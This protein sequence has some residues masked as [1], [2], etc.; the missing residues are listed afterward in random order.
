VVGES[1]VA[2]KANALIAA[3]SAPFTVGDHLHYI[4]ASVGMALFPDDAE[5][6]ETLLRHADASMQ[7]AKLSGRGSSRR[8]SRQWRE[9]MEKDALLEIRLHSALEA[10]EFFLVYQPQVS[11][12]SRK[13]VGFEALIRWR[14]ADGS[15]ISPGQFIPLAERSGLIAEIDRYVVSQGARQIAEWN[16]A[17]LKCVPVSFNLSAGQFRKPGVEKQ[18]VSLLRGRGVDPRNAVFEITE[19][20]AMADLSQTIHILEAWRALGIGVGIDD[21][22]TGFSSLNYLRQFPASSLKIDQSF[23]RGL[24]EFPADR[25]LVESILDMGKKLGLEIVAEG[26]EKPSQYEFLL[27]R[28]CDVIQGYL[29]SKPISA[30]AAMAL[31]ERPDEP[32]AMLA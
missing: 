9:S 4:G 23:V 2:E 19:T 14:Q 7:Q 6:A 28:G 5:D 24:D 31:L 15:L 8:V 3:M 32:L 25:A 17:G 20:A 13:L 1:D 21:F 12:R 27:A 30:D 22:G 11:A 26:V 29:F 16:K 10:G 18:I